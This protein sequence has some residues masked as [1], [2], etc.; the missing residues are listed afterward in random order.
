MSDASHLAKVSRSVAVL[1]LLNLTAT[2]ALAQDRTTQKSESAPL[3]PAAADATKP[4]PEQAFLAQRAGEYTRT[5]K[6]VAQPN[7][8]AST[9]TAK[10]SVTLG[11]RFI[12][13][14]N[15]D[16]VFGRQV[17]GTRIYGFNNLT[18]QY[19][20]VWMYTMST[21]MLF[22]TGTSPDG[23]KTIDLTGMSQNHGGDKIPIHA[24]IRQVDDDQF[25]VT[26]G[27][28]G[29]DGKEAAFQETTYTRKK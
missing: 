11:G 5:V 3:V 6:F 16:T 7:A 19:E 21:A 17:S 2:A 18:K 9:G 28:T 1:V 26:L 29:A 24:T 20:A 13:E 15:T 10:I 4:G 23:G 25:V 22:L 8:D 12:V 27:S 14:E